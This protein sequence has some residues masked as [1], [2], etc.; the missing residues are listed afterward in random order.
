M[1]MLLR[2]SWNSDSSEHSVARADHWLE[3]AMASLTRIS[4]HYYLFLRHLFLR[5]LCE[6]EITC[7][8]NYPS[9]MLAVVKRENQSENEPR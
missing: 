7:A 6:Q 5:H 2:D 4:R 1:L 8:L 3:T 9:S